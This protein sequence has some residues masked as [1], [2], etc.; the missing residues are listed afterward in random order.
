MKKILKLTVRPLSYLHNKYLYTIDAIMT[1]PCIADA[2]E[3]G[4]MLK[5]G[6]GKVAGIMMLFAFLIALGVTI[7]GGYKFSKGEKETGKIMLIGG[8]LVAG[9]VVITKV[10][11]MA[12]GA[13][14]ATS[15]ASFDF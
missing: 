3:A 1:L 6:T 9:A 10:L 2:S 11:F 14:D 5:E 7:I 15:D 13:G 8:G 4:R 12:F